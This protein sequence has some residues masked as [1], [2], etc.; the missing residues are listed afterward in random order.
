V[1][2]IDPDSIVGGYGQAI[3]DWQLGDGRQFA[4]APGSGGSSE[5]NL[6]PNDNIL[7]DA[8][9]TLKSSPTLPDADAI[10][11]K[12]IT[13]ASSPAGQ[14]TGT[15][16]NILAINVYS[17]DYEGL[18]SAGPIYYWD[19]RVITSGG[20]VYT[21]ATGT[22]AYLQNV[23]QTNNAGTP[24]SFPNNGQPRFRGFLPT[25][26]K[27]ISN[28]SGTYVPGDFFRN[29]IPVSGGP[30]GWVCIAA[31][32]DASGFVTDGIVGND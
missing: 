17:A 5:Y 25:H 28:F 2:F 8:Y 29:A 32:F 23:T 24:A 11:Q 31:C 15:P 26:P 16:A 9:F 13:T 20:Q 1:P 6:S 4:G 21:I 14:I 3:E 12:H 30:S 7:T 18:V 19:F 22:V 10:I 27:N